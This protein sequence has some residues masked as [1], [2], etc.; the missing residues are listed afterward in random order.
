MLLWLNLHVRALFRLGGVG[1][2]LDARDHRGRSALHLACRA[3]RAN[4]VAALL[5]A[6]AAPM[7]AEE[8]W[9]G[10]CGH[11]A[12]ARGHRDAVR[13]WAA[14]VAGGEQAAMAAADAFGRSVASLW[15]WHDGSTL[16]GWGSVQQLSAEEQGDGAAP[17]EAGRGAGGGG[18]AAASC[19]ASTTVGGAAD[20]WRRPAPRELQ[21]LDAPAASFDVRGTYEA[22]VVWRVPQILLVQAWL[23]KSV[24]TKALSFWIHDGSY[25]ALLSAAGA[26]FRSQ[27]RK[28]VR[29]ADSVVYPSREMRV[30]QFGALFPSS[31]MH[32][33][34]R[35]VLSKATV[36]PHGVPRYF[37]DVNDGERRDGWLLWPVSPERG[38]AE[39]LRMLP[40]L[41]R[42][43]K[44]RGGDFRVVV[45]HLRG[46]YHENTKLELPDDVVF[47]GMLP[48]K[49]LQT[50]R[51]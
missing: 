15:C 25:L 21:G 23:G 38:L 34:G 14:A 44:S 11:L 51:K 42:A 45:C 26:T 9:G 12:A 28:A 49:R 46:G 32:D 22:I 48:P 43:V 40:S 20:G 24:N 2:R 4:A 3:G 41:R 5:R 27:I 13:A 16:P 47:A 1:E 31:D 7:A 39:L 37:D 35:D 29:V 8:E 19:A 6:G 30:A 17:R 50:F 18:N 36:V 33:G 10:T